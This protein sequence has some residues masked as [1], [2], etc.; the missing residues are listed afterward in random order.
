MKV[1]SGSLND[2]TALLHVRL[3]SVATECDELD[4]SAG[5][6]QVRHSEAAASGARGADQEHVL[7]QFVF[8]QHPSQVT[9]GRLREAAHGHC[10]S[11][12][13]NKILLVANKRREHLFVVKIHSKSYIPK[14]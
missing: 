14:H 7:P 2:L 10:P 11:S 9:K 1:F 13:P 3:C 5:Q 12:K 8:L 6:F 4:F